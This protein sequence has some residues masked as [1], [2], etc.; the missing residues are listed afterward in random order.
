MEQDV[1]DLQEKLAVSDT[2]VN[3]LLEEAERYK[4]A[5][6][7][8]ATL[9]KTNQ[10]LKESVSKLESEVKE[11]DSVIESQKVRIARLAK[12]R[13][14]SV[15]ESLA[16]NES[17]KAKESEVTSLNENLAKANT[18]IESLKAEIASKDNSVKELN[19]NLTKATSLKEAYK[20]LANEAVN[21]YISIRANNLGLTE[22]DIKRKLGE[23]YTLQDI[24][25]VCEDLK[26][27]QLNV[28][29]LPFNIDRKVGVKVNE[30]RSSLP[31]RQNK[32]VYDD[33]EV[34]DKLI[35]LANLG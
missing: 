23:S 28:S 27:Y 22:K 8:L 17:F 12:G 30:S 35:K 11:K 7:R 26:S 15:S 6:A 5:V 25:Q 9:S 34:D 18:Q 32:S 21:R 1:R 13:K 33:D 2:K 16:L 20:K 14:E 29:K 24:D 31:I 3:E 10:G 4:K 19:E